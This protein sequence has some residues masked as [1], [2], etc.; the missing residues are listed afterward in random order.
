MMKRNAFSQPRR[1]VN[2]TQLD[3]GEEL[4][5]ATPMRTTD[6]MRHESLYFTSAPRRDEE[7]AP[8]LVGCCPFLGLDLDR[9]THALFA[10]PAHRCYGANRRAATILPVHQAGHC[11]TGQHITC[12]AYAERL[13]L[14]PPRRRGIAAIAAWIGRLR[15]R[16]D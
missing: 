4:A 9:A 14:A 8:G 16:R 11:L 7:P 15:K 10:T 3:S 13:R 1:V 12:R 2:T 6:R 5:D